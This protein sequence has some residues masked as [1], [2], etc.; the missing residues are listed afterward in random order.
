MVLPAAQEGGGAEMAAQ[1]AAE[2]LYHLEEAEEWAELGQ[3]FLEVH[4]TLQALHAVA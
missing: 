4:D 1:A 2:W 3:A